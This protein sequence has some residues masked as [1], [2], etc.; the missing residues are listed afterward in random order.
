HEARLQAA[1]PGLPWSVK[2][3][4]RMHLINGL[5]PYTSAVDA[6]SQFPEKATARG[7]KLDAHRRVVLTAPRGITDVLAMVIRPTPSFVPGAPLA[8]IFEA[9]IGKKNW[10]A[11][12]PRVTIAGS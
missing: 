3:E 10:R 1:R 11:V 2:N 8:P 9:R 4:A 7:A 6:I 5:P 12:W